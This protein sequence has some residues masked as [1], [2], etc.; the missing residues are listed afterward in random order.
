MEKPGAVQPGKPIAFNV[1]LNEPL[2]KGA[3]FQVRVSPVAVDQQL[4]F[5]S[6]EPLDESRKTFRVSGLL[7]EGAVPGKWHISVIYLFLAGSGW[8]N[9]TIKAN[10][11][12]FE[13][14]G[15]PFPIPN[16]AEISLVR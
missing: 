10:E 6:G 4:Q 13:V 15:K 3:Y 7:P 2:P 11:L 16:Q 14:E 5:A 8:T 1:K 12:T 9:N